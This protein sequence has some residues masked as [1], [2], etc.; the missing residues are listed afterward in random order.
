MDSTNQQG[1]PDSIESETL[2]DDSDKPSIPAASEVYNYLM[3]SVSLPERAL[4][5]TSAVVGGTLHESASLLVPQAF[6]NSKSYETFVQQMLD[7]VV[8]D[9]GRVERD[10]DEEA[11]EI[12]GY[13][14]K[15]AVSGF[16][17]LAGMATLH[18]SPMTV[19]AIVNDVAYG[20]QTYLNELSAELKKAGVI[21][22][23]STINHAADLLDAVRE[24]SSTTANAFDQPPLSVDG[25]KETLQQTIEQVSGVNPTK[26]IPQAEMQQIWDDM[27]EMA[28]REEVGILD[29]S[30]TMSLYAIDKI[31]KVGQG[32]LSSVTVA[33]NLFD[34]HIFEHYREGLG[35][36]REKGLY[37]TLSE[38]SQ[39][40][41]AAVW[42]NFS[43]EK[44]TL[45]ED[46]LTGKLIGRAWEGVRGWFGSGEE[47]EDEQ[48]S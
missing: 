46:L 31:G 8:R 9:V 47:P 44:E 48:A 19:L 17:D 34:R 28:A 3:Y 39:P 27:H 32:A 41:I 42:T 6:R 5:A 14:A 16:L 20:S 1:Q 7:F 13:I 29:V 45:T 15:K 33:G 26:L 4:R 23:K 21:D 10:S 40:Y 43:T 38:S 2:A 25:L 24:A 12:E 11:P 35:E 36:I 18:V 37:A 22:E 30:S